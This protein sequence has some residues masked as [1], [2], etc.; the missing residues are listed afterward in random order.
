MTKKVSKQNF[1]V[2][3][4]KAYN[5]IKRP[6]VSE[7]STLMTQFGQYTFEVMK[8]ATKSEIKEAVQA[9]FSVKVDKVNSL[10]RRSKQVRFRGRIGHTSR[11][12]RAIVKLVEGQTI[13]IGGE[14]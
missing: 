8:T 13:D 4:E 7:K 14:L 2:N 9:I 1:S 10:N 11:S 12:K 3:M 5:I 6:I